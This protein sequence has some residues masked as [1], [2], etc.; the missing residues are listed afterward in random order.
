MN[1][2]TN[3]P[4]VS[5][6]TTNPATDSVVRDSAVRPVVP[7]VAATSA[8]NSE[9]SND[10]ER[11]QSTASVIPSQEPTYEQPQNAAINDPELKD[12]QD[13][14][15][16][17]DSENTDDGSN[18]NSN[19]ESS[20]KG[21]NGQEFTEQ[22]LE[23]IEELKSRDREVVTHELAHA[24]VGGQYAG[25]PSYSYETGPDGV[26][27]AVSGEVSIDTSPIPGDPEATLLKAQQVKRSALAPAEPSAQ[28]RKVAAIAD[29][30]AAEARQEIAAE[31]S[32]T[33]DDNGS[34]QNN[35]F[36]I[37]DTIESD[38][39]NERSAFAQDE[40]FQQTIANRSQHINNFYQ[41]SSQVNETPSFQQQ[42]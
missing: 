14:S 29:Q 10:Q 4:N 31:S 36:K 13:A 21:S 34:E 42:I 41:Q 12:Q 7:P 24:A 19:E 22:E 39:F 17:Q 25:A 38:S 27:Y 16:E 1:I 35:R 26:K 33:A 15:Q 2:I 23:Q 18:N 6:V 28:D 8:T 3:H 5:I 32:V 11:Q 30:I 37:D 20:E 40:E 9:T